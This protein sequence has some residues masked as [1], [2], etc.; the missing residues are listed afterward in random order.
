MKNYLKERLNTYR[1]NKTLVWQT[2]IVT[3]GGTLSLL[4]KALNSKT[5]LVEIILMIVG[6][7]L[8]AFLFYLII[9]ISNE[10]EDLHKKLKQLKQE[11]LKK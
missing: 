4:I 3:T 11:E 2:M 6:I 5:N 7:A 8:T 9:G 10:M 1:T